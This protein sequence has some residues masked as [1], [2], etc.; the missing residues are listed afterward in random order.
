MFRTMHSP[1]R[2]GIHALLFT[3]AMLAC[4]PAY[5]TEAC[6]S[7]HAP[8]IQAPRTAQAIKA[9]A[10]VIVVALGSSTTQ[11]AMASNRGHTYP[12]VLQATLSSALPASHVA[13]LNRGIGGQ[14]AAEELARLDSDVIAA[15]PSLV[16]WQLGGN[17]VLRRTDPALFKQLVLD[18]VGRLH[19]AGAD[20]VLM[21]NQR[22]PALATSPWN[23]GIT[24]AL[25][26]VAAETD[27]DLFSRTE[28]MQAWEQGGHSLAS[29]LAPDGLH[30]NNHGYHCVARALATSLIAGM[31][32]APGAPNGN[33]AQ[34]ARATTPPPG[35]R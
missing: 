21:D 26:E 35:P 8:L 20:V 17:A 29:F 11:G 24:R 12:A 30:H 31:A 5:A 13:V 4:V 33:P 23:A 18:G 34:V 16:I 9:G 32:A 25:A 2:S 22:S 14:D 3:A 6:P 7:W 28:M 1:R 19:A 10:P 27:A 15:R